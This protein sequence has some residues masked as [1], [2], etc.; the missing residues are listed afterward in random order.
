MRFG[1]AHPGGFHMAMCDG[2]VQSY[3]YDIDL[4][5][6]RRMGNRLDGEAV[7]VDASFGTGA[8]IGTKPCP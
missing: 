7:S 3:S 4:E 5:V 1:S 2:S 6:H 8:G